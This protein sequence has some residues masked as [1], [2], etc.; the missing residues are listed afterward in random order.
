MLTCEDT[1]VLYIQLALPSMS[2]LNINTVTGLSVLLSSPA[3]HNE[4]SKDCSCHFTGKHCLKRE[5]K[6]ERTFAATDIFPVMVV[7]LV[8]SHH[9]NEK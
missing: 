3:E 7:N 6:P 1:A 8:Y 5:Q 9:F 2:N 4:Q